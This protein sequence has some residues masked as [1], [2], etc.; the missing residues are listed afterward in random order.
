MTWPDAF[1]I[2][3]TAIVPVAIVVVGWVL[4]SHSERQLQQ[5]NRVEQR[6]IG[7]L[8]SLEGF[9]EGTDTSS[10]KDLKDE[11]LK[12]LRLCWLYCSDMAITKANVFLDHVST[13]A[14]KSEEEQ[15]EALRAFVFQLRKDLYNEKPRFWP[16]SSRQTKLNPEDFRIFSARK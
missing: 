15:Q 1:K 14:T 3:V 8:K 4:N 11:F 13:G 10:A 7:L 6:Y 9:Y 12:E 16:W 5:Y 2:V